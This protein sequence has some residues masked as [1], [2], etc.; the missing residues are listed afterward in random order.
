VFRMNSN[1]R[2]NEQTDKGIRFEK[3]KDKFQILS[4]DFLKETDEL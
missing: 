2:T 4:N 1:S 3:Q